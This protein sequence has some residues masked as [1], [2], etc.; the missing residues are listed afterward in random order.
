MEFKVKTAAP[1]CNISHGH[2]RRML[3]ITS[4]AEAADDDLGSCRPVVS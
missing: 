1:Q 3:I 2:V 4:A